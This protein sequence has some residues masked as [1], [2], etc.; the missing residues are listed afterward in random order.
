VLVICLA[1]GPVGPTAGAVTHPREAVW[2]T[3]IAHDPAKWLSSDELVVDPGGRRIFALMDASYLS[4]PYY[5]PSVVAFDAS[6]GRQLWRWRSENLRIADI[7]ISPDG[8]RVYLAGALASERA[9]RLLALAPATGKVLWSAGHKGGGWQALAVSADGH[10][11]FVGGIRPRT[12]N[13]REL[14]AVVTSYAAAAGTVRWIAPLGAQ[15]YST[16][17]E[18]IAATSDGRNVVLG[19]DVQEAKADRCGRAT[20]T[21]LRASDG[22][23][24][25]TTVLAMMPGC[26]GAQQIGV[27][28]GIV[29]LPWYGERGSLGLPETHVAGLALSDGSKL[30]SRGFALRGAVGPVSPAGRFFVVSDPE[31][32]GLSPR[33]L[34]LSLRTGRTVWGRALPLKGGSGNPAVSRDGRLVYVVG[35]ITMPNGTEAAMLVARAASDGEP[36]WRSAPYRGPLVDPAGPEAASSS[37]SSVV[38]GP[39]GNRVFV[40]GSNRVGYEGEESSRTI[41]TFAAYP[42]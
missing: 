18:S 8:G 14:R 29:L 7:A 17:V 2:S 30:W 23:I 19:I 32:E 37:W 41:P 31:R 6:T 35:A 42:A 16:Y 33:L 26:G 24:R 38:V 27:A 28:E 11:L 34:A 9:S 21:T 10:S 5:V 4:G 39:M 3:A 12:E 15:F 20:A 36:I 1:L 22:N 25:W 40:A 13:H